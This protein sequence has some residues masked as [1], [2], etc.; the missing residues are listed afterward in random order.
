MLPIFPINFRYNADTAEVCVVVIWQ[1]NI[2]CIIHTFAHSLLHFD[3]NA[4]R[5][6][7]VCEVPVMSSEVETSVRYMALRHTD[8]STS[9]GM[10]VQGN[11]FV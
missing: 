11:R 6:S 4:R 2:A 3:R 10:T 9:V 7:V 1:I 5:A 8:S